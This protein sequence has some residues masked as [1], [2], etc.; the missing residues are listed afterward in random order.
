MIEYV[1][2]GVIGVV[3]T[4]IGF[5]V[6]MAPVHWE[7]YHECKELKEDN[8]LLVEE[9]DHYMNLVRPNEWGPQAQFEARVVPVNE[10]P[11][12]KTFQYADNVVYRFDD[13]KGGI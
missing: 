11:Y 13:I 4:F 2:G 7:N 10:L 1:I 8:R 12:D 6:V 3:V 9:R 5:V